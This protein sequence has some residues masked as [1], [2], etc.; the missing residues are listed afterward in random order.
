[1][2]GPNMIQMYAIKFQFSDSIN[3]GD[4]LNQAK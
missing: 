4:Q 2:Y 3:L 1:M